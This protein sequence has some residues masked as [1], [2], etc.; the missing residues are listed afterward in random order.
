MNENVNKTEINLRPEQIAAIEHDQGNV[1]VSASAGSGKTFVMI[2]R[3]ERLIRQKKARVTEI[4]AT[5]FTEASAAD[6]K[7]KLYS[8]LSKLAAETGDED[9]LE[10]L[11]EVASADVTTIDSFSAKLIREFF[12]KVDL[13]P[14]FRIVDQTESG[15]LKAEAIKKTFRTFYKEKN[16][17]FLTFVDKTSVKR[18]DNAL[19]ESVLSLYESLS[20]ETEADAVLATTLFNCTKQGAEETK[21]SL[22]ERFKNKTESFLRRAEKIAIKAKEADYGTLRTY[23]E[24]LIEKYSPA[25]NEQSVY[26]IINGDYAMPRTFGGKNPTDK[27]LIKLKDELVRAKD[28]YKKELARLGECYTNP[29]ED[30]KRRATVEADTAVLIRIIKE[31]EKNYDRIKREENVVDFADLEKFALAILQDREIRTAVRGKYKYVFVD[32]CQDLNRIQNAIVDAVSNDNLFM[33]GDVKQSIYGFRGSC[34]EI[35]E[36]RLAAAESGTGSVIRLNCNFR[37]SQAVIDAVNKVFSFAMTKEVYGADYKNSAELLP[38]GVYPKDCVGRA[39]GIKL[40]KASAAKNE[41]QAEIYDILKFGDEDL[42]NEIAS[43]AKL[44]NEIINRETLNTYYDFKTE[45]HLPVKYGDI[46]ILTRERSSEYVKALVRGLTAF[47]IPVQSASKD[48]VLDY[49]EIKVL[50]AVLMLIENFRSDV[51][52]ATVMKSPVGK[53]TDD[54]FAEI[55]A[56]FKEC[57]TAL[58]FSEKCL[59]YSQTGENETIK[60]KLSDF[61]GYYETLRFLSD[62]RSAAEILEKVIADFSLEAYY[63]SGKYGFGAE[64]RIGFFLSVLRGGSLP[65]SVREA[66]KLISSNPRAFDRETSGGKDAVNVMTMHSSKGLEFPVVIVCGLQ[67]L[68]SKKDESQTFL[69]DARLGF[70]VSYY[71][72]QERKIYSTPQRE[73]IKA[74]KGDERVKEELRLL[75]VALTRA[76]YSLYVVSEENKE[77]KRGSEFMNASRMIEFFPEDFSFEEMEESYLDEIEKIK[78]A[79]KILIGEQEENAYRQMIADLNFVY[80][81]EEDTALP[82][83]NTVTEIV[84]TNRPEVV[85][86][87]ALFKESETKTDA[88]KGIIAH[89]FMEL[90]DIGKCFSAFEEAERLTECGLMK[91]EDI[92]K[93]DLAKLDRALKSPALSNAKKAELFREKSFLATFCAD[94]LYPTRSKEKVLVQGVIDLMMITEDGIEI[95]DYKYSSKTKESLKKSYHKQLELYAAAA[96]RA[97]GKKVVKKTILNLTTGDCAD[98]E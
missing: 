55:V 78:T 92:E 6:M 34:P 15:V 4:L 13:S 80:P 35:F 83:K 14:D 28:E 59:A 86:I 74:K 2:K 38:G 30:E 47:G 29:E 10:Q 46:L 42:K 57:K 62:F 65:Y 1:V 12:Y 37:C 63:S 87:D 73:L 70:A 40:I 11:V 48:C 22:L 41:S 7:R 82:L 97:T 60:R 24:K 16:V 72:E 93:I 19:R 94:T 85:K 26:D 79:D 56:A 71:D 81:F 23:A 25:L 54:D 39:K 52:L 5:T 76:K 18:S 51:P 91:K 31:F 36:E 17:D 27:T 69:K 50:T 9:F 95:V 44:V 45:K 32:E 20:G 75:Y 43:V 61:Y 64:D 58:T 21:R 90:C 33:V 3:I 68:S 49:L 53:L 67:K 89:K 66:L 98:V 96:E 88:E 77:I 84:K 8:A